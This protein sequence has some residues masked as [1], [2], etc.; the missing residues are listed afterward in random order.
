MDWRIVG[1]G[2]GGKKRKVGEKWRMV[3]EWFGTAVNWDG[4]GGTS[5]WMSRRRREE[6]GRWW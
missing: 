5:C 1:D 4:E 3:V 6:E 2:G